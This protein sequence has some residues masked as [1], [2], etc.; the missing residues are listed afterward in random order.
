MT[1]TYN[2]LGW[3]AITDINEVDLQLATI[4]RICTYGNKACISQARTY[5]DDWRNFGT[6]LPN[7]FKS[8]IY[9]TVIKFGTEQDWQEL[10]NIAMKTQTPAEKL[11]MVRALTATTN[12][13]LLQT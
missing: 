12:Y 11:R 7:D 5:Y 6:P 8:V 2:R 4:R 1:N 10:Y 13:K 9:E 3:K